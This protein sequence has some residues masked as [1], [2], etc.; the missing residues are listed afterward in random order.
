MVGQ[1]QDLESMVA[2]K[3]LLNRLNSENIDVRSTGPR[4]EA[5]FR[6]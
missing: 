5:D 3:D 1:F 4:L 2:F 6:A